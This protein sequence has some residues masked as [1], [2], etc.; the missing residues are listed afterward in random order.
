M[1]LADAVSEVKASKTYLE[2]VTGREV[3]SIAFPDGSYTCEL[4][5][6]LYEAGM[7]TQFLVDYRYDDDGKRSF[8]S[9]RVGLYHNMGNGNE[10]VYQ[11]LRL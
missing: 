2:S 7:V 9:D 3:E 6:A 5:D 10:L 11:L 4:N 8:V 1:S